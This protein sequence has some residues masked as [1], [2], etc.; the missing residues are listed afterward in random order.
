MGS[1][2]EPQVVLTHE[3]DLDG[4]VSGLLLQRLAHKMFGVDVAVEAYHY[5]GWKIRSLSE[6]TAWVSD[7]T[8]EARLDRNSWLVVDH[9]A[10]ETKP[11]LATL[12]HDPQKSASLLCYELAKQ[13]GLQSAALDRVV[14][15]TNIGDLF[16]ED[17]PDFVEACDYANLV[18]TYG[19]WNLH[20]LIGGEIERLLDHP[21]LEVIRVK[22]RVEDPMGFEWAKEHVEALSDQVGLVKPVVGNTNVIVHQML[23]RGVTK[24]PVLATLFK[25]GNGTFIVSFRSRNGEALKVASL[26]DGG[27]HPNAAGTTLPRSVNDHDAAS[28]YI[29][30][31]LN[32]KP[33]ASHMNGME[34]LLQRWESARK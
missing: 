21:L 30:Q 24:H 26:L 32:P 8:F 20:S 5:Q 4:L 18:K 23:E 27:G 34:D 13:H 31:R 19:F 6:R 14:E 2:M 7:F 17:H 25:K 22:R 12:I 3:S 16:L 1:L 15:L 10:G 9:H 33:P 29:R 28:E 11:T